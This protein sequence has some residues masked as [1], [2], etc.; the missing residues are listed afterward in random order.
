MLQVTFGESVKVNLASKIEGVARGEEAK[1]KVETKQIE[2]PTAET[3]EE[4]AAKA[5]AP[6]VQVATTEPPQDSVP[7]PEKSEEAAHVPQPEKSEEAAQSKQPMVPLTVA[8]TNSKNDPE[9]SKTRV[10]DLEQKIQSAKQ[11]LKKEKKTE[12]NQAKPAAEKKKKSAAKTKASKKT[13]QGKKGEADDDEDDILD[14][15]EELSNE[16]VLAPESDV[17]EAANE[18]LRFLWHR[19]IWDSIL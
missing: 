9:L 10:A 18:A 2:E 6:A 14:S 5:A 4:A 19:C 16:E 3:K 17:E 1:D 15:E 12:K 8:A 13:K 11:N 7:Q